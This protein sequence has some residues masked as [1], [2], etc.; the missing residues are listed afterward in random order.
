MNCR[1]IYILL[2]PILF[3]SCREVVSKD[4]LIHWLKKEDNGYYHEH[5]YPG[6]TMKV[7]R[8]PALVKALY[9]AGEYTNRNVLDS[10]T[11]TYAG[12]DYYKIEF[13]HVGGSDF[14]TAISK[15][16][17]D[18]FEK[19]SYAEYDMRSEFI[20]MSDGDTLAPVSYVP[21]RTYGAANALT[22]NL[23]FRTRFHPSADL[24]YKGEFM[25]SNGQ[26]FTFLSKELPELK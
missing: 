9:E 6:Y 7:Q 25:K 3:F 18:Y 13:V 17:N 1:R 23:G 22:L 5:Q 24:F 11:S 21:E 10:V 15:D 16:V 26:L 12:M 20:L 4:G 19:L 2:I 14:L 8:V